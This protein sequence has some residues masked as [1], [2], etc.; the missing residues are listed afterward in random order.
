MLLLAAVILFFSRAV[1]GQESLPEAADRKNERAYTTTVSEHFDGLAPDPFGAW[2]LQLEKEAIEKGVDRKTFASAFQGVAPLPRVIE[3]DRSQAE[4]IQPFWMYLSSRV[5]TKRI[6]DGRI[7]LRKHSNILDSIQRKYGVQSRFLVAFWG[8]ETN[9]GQ[10]L[11]SFRVVA[12]LATLAFD[13]R[14]SEFFRSELLDA[15]FILDDGHVMADN[16]LG[17]WAGAMGQTQFMPSTFM[18][19]SVDEDGDG[20]KDIWS[21]LPDAF[22]SAAN[23]LAKLGWNS[24]QT[25]GREIKLPRGFDLKNIGFSVNK[26]L[27]E[28]QLL[29]IR[30]INGRDLPQ[31]Q[32]EGSVI[33]PAGI[34]GPA[35][36]VYANFRTIMKWNRSSLYAISV[37]HLAD[38]IAGGGPLESPRQ[39]E[40][41]LA[42]VDIIK[43]QDRLRSLGFD[44]GESDGRI[45]P[46]T[47]GAIVQFQAAKG[48]P[49]DGYADKNLLDV[50][51]TDTAFP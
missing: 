2:L 8:L 22:G 37:G 48:L 12:A 27:G 7:L 28:W 4:F 6:R 11:G 34:K 5:S 9:F 29:G 43:L 41:P 50:I 26:D 1:P 18:T 49:P 33:L 20:R 38:R 16:M 21:S 15:L 10:N 39:Q 51:T 14:R 3:L 40:L 24:N 30:R 17:S 31:V 44:P 35:F 23:F 32:I 13:E 47:K 25:W 45:G 19:Y 42:R 46:R 36:L